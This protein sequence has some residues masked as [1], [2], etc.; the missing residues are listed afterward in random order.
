[1]EFC[2]ECQNF[3]QKGDFVKHVKQEHGFKTKKAYLEKWQAKA[4]EEQAE[5]VEV[6]EAIIETEQP[7]DMVLSDEDFQQFAGLNNDLNLVRSEMGRMTQLLN[8]LLG[9][10]NELEQRFVTHKQALAEKHGLADLNWRVDL[11]TKQIIQ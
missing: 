10:A 3:I 6:E 9:Q 4:P 7:I 11:Q 5:E 8:A 1:M 2:L